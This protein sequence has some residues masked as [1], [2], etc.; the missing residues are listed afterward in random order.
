MG[1]A[2]TVFARSEPGGTPWAVAGFWAAL[3]PAVTSPALTVVLPAT[4]FEALLSAVATEFTLVPGIVFATALT[5]D[6]TMSAA[7]EPLPAAVA[8]VTAE[9]LIVEATEVVRPPSRPSRGP[10]S[11][12]RC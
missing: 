12:K 4:A 11:A 2:A 9:V 1:V 6:V 5:A 7:A 3:T 10:H 8:E